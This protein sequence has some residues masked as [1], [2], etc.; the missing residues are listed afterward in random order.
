MRSPPSAF[1]RRVALSQL[2]SLWPLS[3]STAAGAVSSLAAL[4]ALEDEHKRL[5]LCRHGQTDWNAENRIQ[6]RTDKELNAV[7]RAQADALSKY[8]AN[9]PIDLVASS[10]LAR[11]ADTADAVLAEHPQA[12]RVPRQA[13]FAEMCFGDYEGLRLEEVA[14]EYKGIQRAW[15]A[16][17]TMKRFPGP[18]GECPNDVARRGLDGLRSLGLL[19]AP[20][21]PLAPGVRG[22]ERHVLVA[23]HG[24]FNKILI[25]A[26]T[27]DVTKASDVEQ[28]NTCLNVLDIAPDGTV[29]TRAL[30]LREHLQGSLR[31]S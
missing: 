7:G 26:L 10:N 5:Y 9:A 31:A 1:S 2:A 11:A 23:A 8:L 17:D 16:G 12:R 22:D 19:P 21:I 27:G 6:G 13:A 29:V 4:P 14:T 18:N 20:T 25:A 30:N 15:R 24:R 28:G 3:F